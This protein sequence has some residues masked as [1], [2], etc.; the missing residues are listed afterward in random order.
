MSSTRRMKKKK[1]NHAQVQTISGDD[2]D[3]YE[4]EWLVDKPKRMKHVH[5]QTEFDVGIVMVDR[6]T[7]TDLNE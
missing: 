7:Q 2:F 4:E 5:S 3:D 1:V 6:V